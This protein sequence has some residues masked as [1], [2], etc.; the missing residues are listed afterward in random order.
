[1]KFCEKFRQPSEMCPAL[2]P[3]TGAVHLVDI[4]LS[5]YASK[6]ISQGPDECPALIRP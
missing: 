2:I 5:A 4:L 1:M 6:N 3:P